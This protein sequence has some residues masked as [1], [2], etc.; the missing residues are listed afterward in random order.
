MPDSWPV[1]SIAD[2]GMHNANSHTSTI[3]DLRFW[4]AIGILLGCTMLHGDASEVVW[5]GV[6]RQLVASS[7]EK[8][9]QRP[10]FVKKVSSA[11]PQAGRPPCSTRRQ[12]R[13]LCEVTT[14]GRLFDLPRSM[15]IRHR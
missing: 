9:G 1:S 10:L 3:T 14:T 7:M 8:R 2:V 13:L 4:T 5:H 11:K 12:T 6:L 15:A